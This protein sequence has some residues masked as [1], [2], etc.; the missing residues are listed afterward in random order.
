MR[1][2]YDASIPPPAPPRWHVAAGYIGGDT[3]HVWTPAE[4]A[5]QP[6]P[7]LLPIWTASNRADTGEAALDDAALI[8]RALGE[9]GVPRGCS[10][11]VDTETVLYRTYLEVLDFELTGAGH[12]LIN[13]GSYS[14]VI[15]NPVT[16]GGRWA[17]DWTDNIMTGVDLVGKDHI[18]AL[19]WANA[20]M[21]GHPWDAS[22]IEDNVPLWRRPGS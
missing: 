11:V 14:F 21:L 17:A 9:L 15:R 19:Q 6:A 1:Q 7:E 10:V 5:R 3:P 8:V 13:Y 16:A 22:V 20:A 2:M 12:P 18:I 4:W